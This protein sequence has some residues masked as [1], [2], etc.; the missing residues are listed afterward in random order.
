MVLDIH[1]TLRVVFTIYAAFW[2][3]VLV[4]LFLATGFLLRRAEKLNRKMHG[5]HH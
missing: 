4:A 1:S 2:T 3:G 5:E